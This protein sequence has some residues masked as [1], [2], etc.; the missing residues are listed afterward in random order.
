MPEATVNKNDRSPFRQDNVRLSWK[1]LGMQSK[2]KAEAVEY[3]S[4]RKF[5][6]GVRVLDPTHHPRTPF[7]A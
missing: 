5:R 6:P 2:P 1:F 4:D 7:R 3:F